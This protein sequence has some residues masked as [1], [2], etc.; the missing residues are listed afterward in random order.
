MSGALR[1]EYRVL[2]R[3]CV[4]RKHRVAH[5]DSILVQ[6]KKNRRRYAAVGR[7]LRVPWYVV[8]VIHNMESGMN[9]RA[10]LHNG[11][12]LTDRTKRRPRGRPPQGEP[13]FVW[14]ESALDALEMKKFHEWTDW[15][16][17]GTLFKLE[18][19]NG[20]GYR[21]YH[22]EV[23]SPYLWS[24]SQHYTKGKYA[25]DGKFDPNLVSG[26]CGAAVL[27]RRMAQK[28]VIAPSLEGPEEREEEAVRSGA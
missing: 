25:S 28:G 23:L 12:P 14:E 20:W 16:V 27:L 18:V 8:G 7:P 3:R 22:P 19:Y 26:Q 1:N 4:I 13:P 21:K 2:F 17:E 15:S 6:L 9:F 10:H 5:V 24:F 11:D